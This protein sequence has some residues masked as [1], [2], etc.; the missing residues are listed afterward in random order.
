MVVA[1]GVGVN[2]AVG[3][4]VNVAV[5]V[6]VNVAVGV[7]VNVTVAVAVGVRVAVGV[8][9]GRGVRVAVGVADG[10]GVRVAVGVGVLVGVWCLGGKSGGTWARILSGT[11][12]SPALQSRMP[13]ETGALHRGFE[14]CFASALR[15]HGLRNADTEADFLFIWGYLRS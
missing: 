15:T 13:S 7:G 8:A 1:V 12:S 10:R 14:E 3:V 9:D 5:A 11:I 4:G 2:D 6:G